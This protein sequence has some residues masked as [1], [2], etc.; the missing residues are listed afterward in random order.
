LGFEI[1]FLPVG[2]ES[3]GGDAIALRYGNLHGTRQEQTVI[4]IDGGY[5]ASGTALVNHIRAYF[6]TERV[7]VVVSTH[8]DQDHASGL[9]VV[10]EELEVGELWMH[11]PWNHSTVLNGLRS[12]AFRSEKLSDRVEASLQTVSDLESLAIAKGIPIVEPFM[13]LHTPDA[14]F[15]VL[16][17]SIDYYEELLGEI[18]EGR[19]LAARILSTLGKVADKAR[20]LVEETLHIETIH[21]NVKTSPRNNTSAITLLTIDDKHALFT[22]DAGIPSLERAADALDILGISAGE[23]RFIQVPHHGSRRNVGPTIL[24]RLLGE[25]GQ[26]TTHAAA[27]VSAPE[28]NP[29]GKHPAKK[30]TNAFSRRGYAVHATQGTSKWHHHEAPGRAGYTTSD[31]LPFYQYVESDDDSS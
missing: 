7:D 12:Q 16:G 23:L 22:G 17:P 1:D 28:K 15:V 3:S 26:A 10:L 4:V 6:K 11:Q 25:K 31:P 2:E 29:D 13:G 27:F 24:D 21:D 9:K 19:S 5:M 14:G 8:P 30:V 20:N 18:A